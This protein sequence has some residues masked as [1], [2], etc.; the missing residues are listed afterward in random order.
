VGAGPSATRQAD[1]SQAAKIEVSAKTSSN[2]SCR[3]CIEEFE[4]D[5]VEVE[6]FHA[7]IVGRNSTRPSTLGPS[8]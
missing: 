3:C 4:E 2:P 7:V 5:E 6:D 8:A 1:A